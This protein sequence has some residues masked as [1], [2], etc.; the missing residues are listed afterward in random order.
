[1]HFSNIGQLLHYK[2]KYPGP[3][4]CLHASDM[5]YQSHEPHLVL[6]VPRLFIKKSTIVAEV[7]A[8]K[9][10][11]TIHIIYMNLYIYIY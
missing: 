6:I 10:V 5:Y 7:T 2:P 9:F 3:Q 11:C 8:R 1:M 4:I